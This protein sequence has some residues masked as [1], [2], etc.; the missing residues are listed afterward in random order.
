MAEIMKAKREQTEA[1]IETAKQQPAGQ[2]SIEARKA[3]LQAQR[4]IL[5]E[6]K[7]K[8]MAQEL[9]DFNAKANNKD[10]LFKE[11]KEMDKNASK[12]P[13]TTSEMEKRRQILKGV[14]ATIEDPLG[15]SAK[16]SN[17]LDDLEAFKVE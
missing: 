8:Q 4:D 3:R 15:M 16:G 7:K 6:H 13:V 14:K 10:T 9:T 2:E 5:R 1:Q 12:L 17:I 11:L